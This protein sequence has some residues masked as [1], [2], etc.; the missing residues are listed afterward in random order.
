MQR[1]KVLFMHGLGSGPAGSK[2]RYLSNHF[3]VVCPDQQMSAYN[4]FRRNSPMRV[5][6]PFVITVAALLTVLSSLPRLVVALGGPLAIIPLAR[7]RM[8]VALARC[9]QLQAKALL[10]HKPDVVVASS[11]GGAVALQ[12]LQNKQ[13]SGPTVLLAPA[14]STRR[15]CLWSLVWPDRYPSVPAAAAAQC[16]VLHGEND[17]SV[18]IDAV[19]TMCKRN[20]I[21]LN[22]ISDGDHRLNKALLDTDRLS[23]IIDSVLLQ[24]NQTGK[25]GLCKW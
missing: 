13:W 5:L 12:C 4:P 19:A 22:I 25:V 18:P 21:L 14:V 6:L 16:V 20:D 3:Q 8:R 15:N 17:N 9:T 11:W 1:P 23:K 7:W 24:C 10:K 2:V